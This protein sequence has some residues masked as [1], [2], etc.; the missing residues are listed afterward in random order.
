[1]WNSS[2]WVG[3]G[4]VVKFAWSEERAAIMR[5]ESV[6]LSRLRALDPTLEV[7]VVVAASDVP[8]FFV[9]RA[10]DG[11]PLS[12]ERA[13]ALSIADRGRVADQLG[14]FLSRL[15]ALP[16]E[17]VVGDLMH[18]LPRAQSDTT[19][20]RERFHRIVDD[21]RA[22]TVL[23]WCDWV[24]GVF[25]TSSAHEPVLAHGDLHGHNQVW[26]ESTWTMRCILDLGECGAV[27]PEFDL[28][29]L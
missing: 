6:V 4:H 25:A 3:P 21:A 2:A 9:T 5:R 19:R 13:S 20:L 11:V 15:H 14:G 7:P 18:L 28:R 23:G 22:H 27:E 26:D 8:T 12:G 1:Y 24:D 29:Y 17:R 16:I 10:V